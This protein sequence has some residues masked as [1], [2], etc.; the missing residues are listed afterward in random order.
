[1]S[2]R[3]GMQEGGAIQAEFGDGVIYIVSGLKTYLET[4][5]PMTPIGVAASGRLPAVRVATNAS[6]LSILNGLD[7]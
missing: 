5:E 1:M 4:V 7:R 3:S 6:K 2:I